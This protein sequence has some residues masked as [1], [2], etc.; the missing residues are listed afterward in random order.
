[1]W[2]FKPGPEARGWADFGGL[3]W[4]VALGVTLLV[5]LFDG[6]APRQHL[7]WTPLSLDDPI[8]AAT[9]FK[10]SKAEQDRKACLQLLETNG[11]RYTPLPDSDDGGFCVLENIVR[12]DSGITRLSPASVTMTCPLAVRMVLWDRQVVQPAAEAAFGRRVARIENYGTYSCRRIYGQ[13][14]GRPSEHATAN[15]FD[16]S[17]VVLEG[18]RRVSVLDDWSAEAPEGSF[19]RRLRDGACD[20]FGVV[21]SPEYNAAH[22]NH[23]HFDLSAWKVCR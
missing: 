19:L 12:I 4:E 14:E 8:G 13:A 23:L 18:G 10:L 9:S 16:F 20:V 15:A 21:L 3:L 6:L 7:P 5:A 22:A 11:V 17:A 1:M 2:T